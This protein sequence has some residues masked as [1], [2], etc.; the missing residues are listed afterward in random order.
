M[1]RSSHDTTIKK[2]IKIEMTINVD[3]RKDK[4]TKIN[5][6]RPIKNK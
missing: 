2:Q 6:Q 4:Q 5:R 1:D 3:T